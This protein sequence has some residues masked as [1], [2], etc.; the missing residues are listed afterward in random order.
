M[1]DADHR[2]TSAFVRTQVQKSRG[3]EA[4]LGLFENATANPYLHNAVVKSL[5]DLQYL[6]YRYMCVYI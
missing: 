3:I 1:R 5:E 4:A 2:F 6:T